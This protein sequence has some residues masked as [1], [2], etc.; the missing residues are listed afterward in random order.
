M[1]HPQ[2]DFTDT[3]RAV[4]P[5]RLTPS[6]K[7]KAGAADAKRHLTD[8]APAFV[9]QALGDALLA[10]NLPDC[11]FT[12]EQVRLL[13]EKSDAVK[14]WLAVKGREACYGGWFV[15]RVELHRLERTGEM[16]RASRPAARGR[17][18]PVWRFPVPSQERP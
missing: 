10:Y 14:G 13:A 17:Y 9:L 11:D 5:I 15:S 7:G 3:L 12:A 16:R 2:L 1:S 8:H 18:L 4:P 6:D